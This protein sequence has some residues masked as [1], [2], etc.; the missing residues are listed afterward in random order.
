MV[1]IRDLKSTGVSAKMSNTP[2]TNRSE[3][4]KFIESSRNSDRDVWEKQITADDTAA[5]F[6]K[7]KKEFKKYNEN[8]FRCALTIFKCDSAS[9]VSY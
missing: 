5:A 9:D 1:S 3:E 8:V 2:L 4:T 6:Y 7:T